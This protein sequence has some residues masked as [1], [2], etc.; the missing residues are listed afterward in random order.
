MIHDIYNFLAAHKP[1]LIV[2]SGWLMRELTHVPGLIA[3]AFSYL[4]D[5][6]GYDGIKQKI[7]HGKVESQPK[8]EKTNEES[9][10]GPK[11][12]LSNV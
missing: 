4:S 5:N 1:A 2:A 7:L 8:K 6:G 10:T 9:N 3:R 12:P 11:Y